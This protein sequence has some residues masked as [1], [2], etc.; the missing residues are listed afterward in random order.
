MGYRL[1]SSPEPVPGIAH[2]VAVPASAKE[3]H[4][5][6]RRDLGVG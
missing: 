1:G 3:A 6:S 5:L 4:S 2:P